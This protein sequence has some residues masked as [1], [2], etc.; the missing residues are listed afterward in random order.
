MDSF[1][2][3]SERDPVSPFVSMLWERGSLYESEVVADLG[4]PFL[5]LSGFSGDEKERRTRIAMNLPEL[6]GSGLAQGCA[7]GGE[8][9]SPRSREASRARVPDSPL[10]GEGGTPEQPGQ[11]ENVCSPALFEP[12]CRTPDQMRMANA[13]CRYLE[14][15]KAL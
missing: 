13:F 2:S 14:L 6:P 4:V 8:A 9:A 1:G 11:T 10:P 3:P 7:N 5:D 15:A 12:E